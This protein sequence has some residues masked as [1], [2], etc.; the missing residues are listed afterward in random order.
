MTEILKLVWALVVIAAV[1]ALAWWFTRFAASRL[2]GGAAL[3]GKH[4]QVLESVSL[5]REQKLVL[6]KLGDTYCFLGVTP[7][8]VTCLRQ[9]S[10]EEA[11]AEL[12]VPAEDTPPA[13]R[14]ALGRVLEQRRGGDKR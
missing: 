11:E 9:L 5:G 1:L 13:F 12:T 6:A 4:L 7:G 10:R 8:G 14:E 2:G 3:R